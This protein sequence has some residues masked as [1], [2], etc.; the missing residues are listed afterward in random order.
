MGYKLGLLLSS[1][2]MMMVLLFGGDLFCISSIHSSLD[3]LSLIVSYRIG[4]DG[5][6]SDKTKK[7]VSDAGV[8]LIA[9]SSNI[10]RLGDVLEYSLYKEYKP[11]IL[12]K[13]T[14]DIS[15]KRS[16]IV[17]YYTTIYY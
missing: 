5:Y 10:P 6:I 7:L 12:S 8:S 9:Y 16:A 2:F 1:V 14:I 13:N 4:I 11:L 3:S 17:G 15:V